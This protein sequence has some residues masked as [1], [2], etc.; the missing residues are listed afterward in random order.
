MAGDEHLCSRRSRRCTPQG[1]RSAP[2]AGAGPHGHARRR[3][4]P[5]R[6]LETVRPRSACA[7]RELLHL[8]QR[9]AR[10]ASS[11]YLDHYATPSTRAGRPSPRA[12]RS[13]EL[14]L[15]LSACLDRA[16]DEL[17][18]A[19]LRGV[20]GGDTTCRYCDRRDGRSPSATEFAG[21]LPCTA[22]ARQG[23]VERG[24]RRADWSACLPHA[25]Q[26]PS[27]W[28]GGFRGRGRGAP[29][30]RAGARLAGRWR[31]P[32]SRRRRD[33]LRQP[34]V[35]GDRTRQGWHRHQ[36][37]RRRVVVRR[38]AR[39]FRRRLAGRRPAS[40]RRRAR[41]RPSISQSRG[42][43]ARRP[44]SSRFARCSTRA[45][46]AAWKTPSLSSSSATRSVATS[47]PPASCATYSG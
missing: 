26:A 2:A 43:P 30:A 47:P 21:D 7:P 36:E 13:G 1:L 46:R 39:P 4:A 35:P 37:G 18:F 3:A 31:G 19:V 6:T 29:L 40:R 24:G 28:R 9:P 32:R 45:A 11:K 44:I 22:R 15:G 38:R 12:R 5:A 16:D 33:H 8:R 23:H 10:G 20:L 34:V 41:R 17:R 42:R 25:R 27:T 14:G